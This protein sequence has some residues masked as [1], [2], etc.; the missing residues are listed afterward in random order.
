[1]GKR[2]LKFPALGSIVH[3]NAV[4]EPKRLDNEPD[5][6]WKKRLATYELYKDVELDIELVDRDT[7]IEWSNRYDLIL[8][9]EDARK[10]KLERDGHTVPMGFTLECARELKA[11]QRDVVRR[12]VKAIRPV[13]VGDIDLETVADPDQRTSLIEQAGLLA[14]AAR[15]AREA[16][17]PSPTQSES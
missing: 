14:D 3:R 17:Q 11:Y 9:A 12:A 16:Q 13:D 7:V 1:M 8:S 15:E 10:L 5:E 4:P 6:I 2:K